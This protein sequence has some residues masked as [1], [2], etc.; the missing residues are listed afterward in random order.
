MFV[1]TM[2]AE[3][4]FSGW[5]YTVTSPVTEGTDA[6]VQQ[7][8]VC[9]HSPTFAHRHVMRWIKA[10]ST[11]ITDGSGT[12][13]LSVDDVTGSKGITVIFNQPQVMLLTKCFDCF[14]VKWISKGMCQHDCFGFFTVSL[15]QFCYINVV[16][17][18][19]HIHKHRYCAILNGRRHCGRKTG[20]YGNDLI[21]S[22][23][24][25]FTKK[26]RGQRHKCDQ[27]CR[28]SGID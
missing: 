24:S 4:I 10:G 13:F 2:S 18:N 23:D 9:I 1:E 3:I 28:G 14:Q 7:R 12:F 17:W 25:A 15:F 22:F 16:L 20:C 8:I 6:F 19:R 5:T 11:D 21:A 26:R 27:I